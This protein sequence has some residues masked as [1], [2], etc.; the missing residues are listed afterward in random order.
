MSRQHILDNSRKEL[1]EW[2]KNTLMTFASANGSMGHKIMSTTGTGEWVVTW[3][4][5]EVYRGKDAMAARTAYNE[6]CHN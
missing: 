1:K 3:R 4:Q 5:D 6:L 2:Q